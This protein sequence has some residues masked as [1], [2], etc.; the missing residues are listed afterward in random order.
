[1]DWM[2]FLTSCQRKLTSE[3]FDNDNKLTLTSSVR[4]VNYRSSFFFH[5]N[6]KCGPRIRLMRGMYSGTSMARSAK[7]LGKFVRYVRYV[8]V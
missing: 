4:I 3:S 2:R 6:L 5:F 7:G 8:E 1:M